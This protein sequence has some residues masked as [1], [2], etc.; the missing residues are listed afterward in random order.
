MMILRA[1]LG[2]LSK[3]RPRSKFLVNYFLIEVI[4]P[5]VSDVASTEQ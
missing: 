1:D 3:L 5:F 2:N 4:A